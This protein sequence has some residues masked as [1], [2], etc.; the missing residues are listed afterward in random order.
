MARN[1][2]SVDKEQKR[3]EIL[4]AARGLFLEHGFE[5]ASM[6]RVAEAAGIAP[7]TIYWYFEN[8][9]QLL[10]TVLDTMFQEN[11]QAYLSQPALAM[12]LNKTLLWLIRN[13]KAAAPLIATLHTRLDQSEALSQWHKQYHRTVEAVLGEALTKLGVPPVLVNAY[14]KIVFYAIEGLIAHEHSD[15]EKRQV[16]AMLARQLPLA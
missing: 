5:A 6:P 1:K 14:V 3:K 12:D 13:L 4:H 15:K 16:C 8:K 10:L 7:T 11:L 2:R 9:D